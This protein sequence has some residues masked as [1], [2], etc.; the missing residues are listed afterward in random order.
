MTEYQQAR[1]ALE[2]LGLWPTPEGTAWMQDKHTVAQFRQRLH[3][4]V[5]TLEGGEL[6]GAYFFVRRLAMKDTEGMSCWLAALD[7]WEWE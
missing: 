4:L 1:Y 3:K 2:R 7:G 6:M 5:D